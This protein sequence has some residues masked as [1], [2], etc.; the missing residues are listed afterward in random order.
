LISLLETKKESNNSN[1]KQ[2]KF[3]SNTKI[4]IHYHQQGSRLFWDVRGARFFSQTQLKVSYGKGRIICIG[5]SI[6]FSLMSVLE[7]N[8]HLQRIY[9]HVN[10][11]YRWTLLNKTKSKKIFLRLLTVIF[12]LIIFGYKVISH[13]IQRRFWRFSPPKVATLVTIGQHSN[14]FWP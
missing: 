13:S 8:L 6:Q 12:C 9:F 1:R 11:G 3:V 2:R 7:Q 4:Y 10:R 14:D 5:G